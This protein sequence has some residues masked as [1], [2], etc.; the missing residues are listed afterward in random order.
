VLQQLTPMNQDRI[1]VLFLPNY[2]L[3]NPY[4]QLLSQSVASYGVDVQLS[5]GVGRLPILGAISKWGTPQILHLHWTQGFLTSESRIKSSI[6]AGRFLGELL[7]VKKK[8]IKLI[9]TVHNLLSH[10]RQVKGEQYINHMLG[11]LCNHMI[12]HSSFGRDAVKEAYRLPTNVSEKI[13]VIPHGHFLDSYDNVV[14]K[15]EARAQLGLPADATVFLFFGA[16]RPYKGV[17]RLVKAFRKVASPKAYLVI[18]GKPLNGEIAEEIMRACEGDP[19]I[20]LCLQNVPAE[21]I[22]VYMNASDVTVFP[23]QDI[24]TSGSVLLAMSFG[25]AIIAAQLRYLREVIDPEGALF[26]RTDDELECMLE[27]ALTVDL[28]RMGARNRVRAQSFNWEGIG[29]RTSELYWQVIN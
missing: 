24:F 20:H 21:Q 26:Y 14:S 19:R 4:Q 28:A 11:H 7:A 12:V 27:M 9:W 1:K 10:E 18:A 25:K 3:G 15:Q 22:Q 5:D 6:L 13:H 16:I 29:R 23:Y 17:S 8:G 2:S